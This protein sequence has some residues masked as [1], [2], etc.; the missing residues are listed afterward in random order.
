MTI[1]K[2]VIDE[3]LKEY[4]TPE[5]LVG[6]DGIFKQLQ[7]ALIERA[8]AAEMTHHLGTRRTIPRATTAAI[9]GTGRER[10]Q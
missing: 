5:D 10:R 4:K 9:Q 3:L 1:K 7:K 8:M 6:K 2:E